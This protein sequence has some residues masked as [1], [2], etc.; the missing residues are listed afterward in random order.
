M[1]DLV[2]HVGRKLHGPARTALRSLVQRLGPAALG[3]G[4]TD[5]TTVQE[6]LPYENAIIISNSSNVDVGRI[7]EERPKAPFDGYAIRETTGQDWIAITAES[8]RAL[9]YAVG[10]FLKGIEI[11]N[12]RLRWS[13]GNIADSPAFPLRSWFFHDVASTVRNVCQD[14]IPRLAQ[15]L[16][17][18]TVGYSTFRKGTIGTQVH[19]ADAFPGHP[20]PFQ[21]N[22][23]QIASEREDLAEFLRAAREYGFDVFAGWEV[24][25]FPEYFFEF[26]VEHYPN[27]IARGYRGSSDWPPYEWQE[28]PR[29]CPSDPLLWTLWQAAV[30]EFLSVHQDLAGLVLAFYDGN[31]MGC[32]CPKC[33]GYSYGDRFRDALER[34]NEVVR[35]HKKKMLVYDWLPGALSARP[36]YGSFWDASRDYIDANENITVATWETAGDF[37]MGHPPNPEIGR[38]KRQIAGFQLWPEYRGWGKVP[39]WM[40]GHMSERVRFFGQKKLQG[41]FAV[42]GNFND[43]VNAVNFDA[44]GELCWN[45]GADPR[46]IE[47]AY[48]ER[49]YGKE[50]TALAQILAKSFECKKDYLY[51]HDVK[52]NGH[53]H[54]EYD[55][56]TWEAVYVRY[57]SGVFFPDLENRLMVSKESIA[58]ILAEKDRGVSIA[59]EMLRDFRGI[60]NRLSQPDQELIG[61]Q[62]VRNLHYG[63]LW[64]GF[65]RAFFNL[66]YLSADDTGIKVAERREVLA[67]LEAGCKEM[68]DA[69]SMLPKVPPIGKRAYYEQGYPWSS[70]DLQELIGDLESAREIHRGIETRHDLLI[71]GGG[72][73]SHYLRHLFLPYELAE[74]SSSPIGL[75]RRKAV[76][77]DRYGTPFFN[78]N[79]SELT[80]YLEGGGVILLNDPDCQT[81]DATALPGFARFNVCQYRTAKVIER[82]HPILKGYKDVGPNPIHYFG[83]TSAYMEGEISLNP[84][85]RQYG[86]GDNGWSALT[87]PGMFFERQVGKGTL[88]INLL[89]QNR[90]IYLRTIAYLLGRGPHRQGQQVG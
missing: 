71:I 44:Y 73:S 20:H 57:D 41:Y 16:R 60:M 69:Y 59:A 80:D 63:R 3:A 25:D 30:D 78:R 5:S 84:G 7:V 33:A 62:L 65:T 86:V 77:I 19:M 42:E 15:D 4:L 17:L 39:D 45:P 21:E 29:Y 68:K 49:V 55:L 13:K 48:C 27:L 82:S 35:R 46:R 54:I 34:T 58:G 53:S 90:S 14:V 88:I 12:A 83:S 22:A 23:A 74:E 11:D 40:V 1:R 2:I 70:P 26:A 64:R 76:I 43:R 10:T 66:K 9:V 89:S 61:S 51:V 50:S 31:Q 56:R 24:L 79:A 85:L 18:N 37:C 67:D 47:E 52:F 81:L 6:D 8:G 32:G 38:Y 87:N 75:A 28:R 36:G 72:F